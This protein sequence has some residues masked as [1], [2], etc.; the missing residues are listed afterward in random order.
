MQMNPEQVSAIA[1]LFDLPGPIEISVFPE[2]GNINRE[3]YLITAGRLNNSAEYI[4]QQLNP[5]VFKKP[6]RVMRA[7]IACIEA[8]QKAA[9]ERGL[10]KYGEWETV[11]LI[12]TKD[13]D[14]YLET[15]S[16]ERPCC[17][18]VMTRIRQ[19]HAYKN[20]Q[21]IPD[22]ATRL[23]VAQEAA[24]GLAMFG[25]LT[26]GMDPQRILSPLPGYRDT[27]LY[28]DQ[29]YS[30]LAGSRSREDAESFL[31]E[32]PE[33]RQDTENYFLIQVPEEEFRRR[34]QDPLIRRYIDLAIEH[35]AYALKLSRELGNGNLNTRVIHGDTK[36]E[37]FLFS[38]YTGRAKALV[39]LDTIMPHTWLSDWGDMARSL[40][41]TAGER[42]RDLKKVAVDPEIFKSAARGFLDTAFHAEERE[43]AMM[44]E[45]A[46]IMAL[47]LGVRFLTDYLRGDNYFAAE[48]AD[49]PDLNKIRA[50]VQF[51][52]FEDFRAKTGLI[53]RIIRDSYREGKN[54][55]NL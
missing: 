48:P 30:V 23:K 5:N 15:V 33:L 7:M 2:K 17:W 39:D 21:E 13:G 3:A 10:Q 31:P 43:V 28:Y 40:A 36:L 42:E 4:L 41:N 32:D 44:G 20:L 45:A 35:K 50:L 27:G 14:P 38:I 16:E 25:T 47:E 26:A 18:R 37:N 6:V 24:R 22:P 9:S 8:Q 55:S 51:R 1:S 49:P 34:Y 12:P 54:A 53:D 19:V 29:F 52:L 11:R 46:Q